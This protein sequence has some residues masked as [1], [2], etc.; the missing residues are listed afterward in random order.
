MTLKSFSVLNIVYANT[1]TSFIQTSQHNIVILYSP[2]MEGNSITILLSGIEY[3]NDDPTE[4][5]VL[6]A[7]VH[8]CDI[9]QTLVDN[10]VDYCSSAGNLISYRPI[11]SA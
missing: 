11:H 2:L 6:Y 3:M 9:L 7:R 5:D 10:V 8:A 4:V 1:F